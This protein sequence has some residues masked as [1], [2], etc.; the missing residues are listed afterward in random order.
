MQPDRWKRVEDLYHSALTREED[1]RQQFLA[2]A[3][4]E[5]A[6]LREEVES[7]LGADR[8]AASFI[9]SPALQVA[10]QL[11][12]PEEIE[13]NSPTSLTPGMTISHYRILNKIGAGGMGEVYRAHD[14][15]LGRDVAIKILPKASVT[16][17]DRLKRF[18]LEARSTA[19]LNHPNI[20]AIYD[21]GT[22][23]YGTPYVVT[24][25]LEGETLR[26]CLQRGPLPIRDHVDSW[27]AGFSQGIH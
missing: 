7:L 16:D 2:D 1:E 9:E 18:E 8:K 22:W 14:P 24:E 19:A 20:V 26:A 10:A 23:E 3:C 27:L 25:L 6:E 11:L 5:D 17:P 4:K 21:V 13:R 15:R 12:T